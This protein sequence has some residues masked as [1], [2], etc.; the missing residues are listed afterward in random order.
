[1]GGKQGVITESREKKRN[2]IHDGLQ[3][4]KKITKGVVTVISTRVG[5]CRPAMKRDEQMRGAHVTRS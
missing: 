4:E 2:R 1:M 3:G 5:N